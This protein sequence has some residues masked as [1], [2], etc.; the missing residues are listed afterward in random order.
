MPCYISSIIASIISRD[1]GRYMNARGILYAIPSYLL[2]NVWGILS[3]LMNY[4]THGQRLTYLSIYHLC[5]TSSY[6]YLLGGIWTFG[7][8]ISSSKEEEASNIILVFNFFFFFNGVCVNSMDA[9]GKV[10]FLFR[11][12]LKINTP[13][14]GF[15]LYTYKACAP[16]K[17]LSLVSITFSFLLS[18]LVGALSSFF[19]GN[20]SVAYKVNYCWSNLCSLDGISLG[21]T[22]FMLHSYLNLVK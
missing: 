16:W 3:Y 8:G 15:F 10:S 7:G 5:I 4:R 20:G 22:A 9:I 1:L 17:G 11:E 2:L 6:W 21:F 18:Y 14:G 19:L 13:L 12:I